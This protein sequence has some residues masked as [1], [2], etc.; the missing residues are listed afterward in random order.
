[1]TPTS[2]STL[3]QPNSN[4]PPTQPTPLLSAP[5]TLLIGAT[6]TGK[7]HSLRT[8]LEMGSAMKLFAIYTEPNGPEVND[9]LPRDQYHFR[10]IPAVA[11]N[12]DAMLELAQKIHTLSFDSLSKFQDPNRKLYTEFLDLLTCLSNFK[13]DCC[14][15]E[16]GPVD[17]FPVKCALA[18]DSLSGIN[19]MA[20]NLVVGGKPV[21]APGD[22]AIAMTAIN[23]LI[24]RL[25]A[26][27]APVCVTA[28]VERETDEATGAMTLMASTLGRKLA[29]VLPRFF[30]DTIL[31][32]RD[33]TKYTWSTA[34]TGV[35]LK[36][37]NLPLGEGLEP[38]FKPILTRWAG[39]NSFTF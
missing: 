19:P 29:P 14:G 39:R 28:H 10:Y 37:R 18:I 16:W 20:M 15:K 25:T 35:D 7:T 32:K 12:W 27:H 17:K 23:N 38:S 21:K 24:T 4:P 22:W 33:G 30:S 2:N 11:P 9:D 34:A 1:M 13:C 6:G 36:A 5:K 8:Y 3:L 31:A 26:I